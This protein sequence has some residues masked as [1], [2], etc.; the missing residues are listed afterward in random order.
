MALNERKLLTE[1]IEKAD[2]EYAGVYIPV[3]RDSRFK[4]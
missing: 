1:A 2:A 4:T 3:I